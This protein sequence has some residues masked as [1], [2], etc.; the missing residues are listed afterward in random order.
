[1]T[2]TLQQLV[3]CYPH[4]EFSHVRDQDLRG[5]ALCVPDEEVDSTGG[6]HVEVHA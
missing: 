5:E 2:L 3:C 6:V 4:P 1:M